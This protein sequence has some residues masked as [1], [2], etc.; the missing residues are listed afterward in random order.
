MKYI[1]SQGA[2]DL[3][4]QLSRYRVEGASRLTYFFGLLLQAHSDG[5]E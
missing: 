1:S 3:F 2:E 4:E 5:S